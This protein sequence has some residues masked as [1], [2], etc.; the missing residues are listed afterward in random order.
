MPEQECVLHDDIVLIGARLHVHEIE[1]KWPAVVRGGVDELDAGANT[2][3]AEM[4]A[5]EGGGVSMAAERVTSIAP[6]GANATRVCAPSRSRWL[7]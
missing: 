4:V 7:G 3:P 1:D 2:I 6:K 5:A